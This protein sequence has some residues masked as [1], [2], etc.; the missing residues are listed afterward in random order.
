[1]V[2]LVLQVG[3]VGAVALASAGEMVQ[4][5]SKYGKQDSLDR[6]PEYRCH[7]VLLGYFYKI[8]IPK[9]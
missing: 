7:E 8:L 1:L 4:Q 3:L 5:R 6:I 9:R 2:L